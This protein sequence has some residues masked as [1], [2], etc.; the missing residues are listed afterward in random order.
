MYQSFNTIRRLPLIG[1]GD[2]LGVLS[3]LYIDERDFLTSWFVIDTGGWFSSNKV[4]VRSSHIKGIDADGAA[5]STDLTRADIE[6]APS[7]KSEKTVDDV[8]STGWSPGAD[9]AI[10][11]M[12]G[13]SPMLPTSF[14]LYEENPDGVR[15]HTDSRSVPVAETHLRS[16]SDIL[17]YGLDAAD[18]DF[19]SVADLVFSDDV[20]RLAYVAIDTGN[21]LPGRVV[22]LSPEWTKPF[23]WEHR[24]IAVDLTRDQIRQ[25][26]PLA[27]LAG[28]ERSYE[29][30]LQRYY[31]V[32]MM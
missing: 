7:A 4:L 32:P 24:K 21:W 25:A 26:P 14:L 13:T 31:G 23:V 28:L 29:T 19:G 6:N 9:H 3:D 16:A 2:E 1:G 27:D 17:G 20:W 18:G 11:S 10:Y 12:A 8:E 30:D 15:V 5:I 22:V